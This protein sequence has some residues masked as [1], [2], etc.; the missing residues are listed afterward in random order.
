VR[1]LRSEYL[2][3][4]LIISRRQ[5]EHA[6]VYTA[7]S[8][9]HRPHRSLSLQPPDKNTSSPARAAARRVRRHELLGGLMHEYELAA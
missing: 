6:L 5:L 1:T 2:D 3:R 4:I 8:N 7:H 9:R